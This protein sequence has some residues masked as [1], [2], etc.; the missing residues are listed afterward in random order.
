MCLKVMIDIEFFRDKKLIIYGTGYVARM[1]YKALKLHGLKANI[2]CYAV[3]CAVEEVEI[4]DGV[5]VYS[6]C[7][8]VIDTNAVICIAVH[9]ANKNEIEDMVKKFTTR[10][11]WVYPYIYEFLLGKPLQKKAVVHVENLLNCYKED[12]RLAVRLAAIEYHDNKNNYGAQ[13]YVNAQMIHCGKDTS[14][15]RLKQF[16]ALV[17]GWKDY[18]YNRNFPI[19][20]NSNGEVID[21]DHRVSMAVYTGQKTICSDVYPSTIP[22][23]EIHGN[24]AMMQRRTLMENG[25]TLKD[26]EILESIQ[27]RYINDYG[28]RQT[29]N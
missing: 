5:P 18:G 12:L 29:I 13:Y 14:N 19:T 23:Q 16:M 15:K 2:Q 27:W 4:F 24:E 22:V 25:F 6:I 11:I 26:I 1:F 3:S 7:D 9:E 28:R 20:I 21:G 10:Y 17:D 8:I